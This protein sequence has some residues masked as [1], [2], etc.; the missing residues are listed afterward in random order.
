[1]IRL[2]RAAGCGALF[3]TLAGCYYINQAAG[4]FDIVLNSRDIED[5]YSDPGMTDARARK[6]DLV[7][8]S[9]RFAEERLGLK[10]SRNY[11]TYF[12]T[13]RGAVTYVVSAC[14]ADAFMP[15]LWW[16]P[17]VGSLPY[18]GYFNL[19]DALA[20]A[21]ALREAGWD[22]TVGE[23]AAYS[24][25]GWF[26]DPV[27]SSMLSLSDAS[28]ASTVIHELVH[29]TIYVPDH[30]DFNESLATFVGRRGALQLFEERHGRGSPRVEEVRARF[31][32]EALFDDF[33]AD[34]Y[35]RLSFLYASDRTREEKLA[36]REKVFA[37]AREELKAVAANFRSQRRVPEMEFNNAVIVAQHRYGRYNQFRRVFERVQNSWPAFFAAVSAAASSANPLGAVEALARE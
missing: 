17:I 31:E 14:R 11:T 12:D 27:F 7:A 36:E 10:P 28:L 37:G 6:L 5:V 35:A 2:L 33:I 3:W 21:R 4:Q 32:D 29:G 23:S 9:R 22:V 1:M 13:G 16:F 30:S 26:R 19:E 25:L 20:E 18:K 8:A 34:L 15:Y 24:T